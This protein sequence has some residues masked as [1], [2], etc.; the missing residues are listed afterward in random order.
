MI[1]AAKQVP[2]MP[3]YNITKMNFRN[4]G[5][6][7]VAAEVSI[8]AFNSFPIEVDVPPLGFDIYVPNC[9]LYDPYILVADAVTD[10]IGVRPRSDVIANVH[11]LVRELPDSLTRICPN[12]G[13]SPLDALL[14]DYLNGKAATVFVRGKKRPGLDIP[15]WLEAI[16][17][18]VDVPVPFPGRTFDGLIRNFS[19]TDTHFTLPDPMADPDD[20]EANPKVSGNIEVIAGL[21]SDMNFDINVTNVRASAD[22]FYHKKKLGELDIRHWQ[23]ANSTKTSPTKEHDAELR[24]QS[25]IKNAPIN[26]TDGDVLSDVIQTLF[27]G[28]KDVLLDIKALVDVK[29]HTPLGDLVLK[30]LP[31]EGKIP[32]KRPSS[33]W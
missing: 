21:P 3:Q 14:K 9:G 12:S 1:C 18:S 4:A 22:V 33:S 23:A 28:G 27:F 31:A 5:E 16:L 20:P 15:D 10:P 8:T 19:L 11:G 29:I 32:V 30:D 7:A 24:I 26:V 6:H 2:E 17:A 25:I 13:S